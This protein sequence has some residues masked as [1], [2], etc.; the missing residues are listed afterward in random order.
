MKGCHFRCNALWIVKALWGEAARVSF[1]SSF[2]S[3]SSEVALLVDPNPWAYGVGGLMS[4][5]TFTGSYYS[6]Q[7]QSFLALVWMQRRRSDLL[8]P[9]V[10]PDPSQDKILLSGAMRAVLSPTVPVLSGLCEKIH[11]SVYPHKVIRIRSLTLQKIVLQVLITSIVVL[12]LIFQC[13]I[14]SIECSTIKFQEQMSCHLFKCLPCQLCG[15]II[16]C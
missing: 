2:D 3:F 13:N 6:V 8:L 4:T 1:L 11:I 12:W 14:S 15:A 7:F 9:S 5:W 10:L 16:L